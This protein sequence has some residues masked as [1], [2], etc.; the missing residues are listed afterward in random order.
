MGGAQGPRRSAVRRVRGCGPSG[1]PSR[2]SASGDPVPPLEPP[3]ARR[4]VAPHDGGQC[5]TGSSSWA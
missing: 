5:W 4:R 2:L 1:A 3:A